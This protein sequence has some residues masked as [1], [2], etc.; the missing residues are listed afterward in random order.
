M[1]SRVV[2]RGLGEVA[3]R[4]QLLD[5]LLSR[6]YPPKISVA[7]ERGLSQMPWGYPLPDK[8]DPWLLQ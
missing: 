2:G 6:D 4:D 7:V 1:G 8:E 3:L 5:V